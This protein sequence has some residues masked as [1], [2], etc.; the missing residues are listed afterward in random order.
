MDWNR[1]IERNS[2]VLKAI[3]AVLFA[4]LGLQG[5]AT[6]DRLPRPLHRA[7]LGILR[8][9]ESALRRLIVIAARGL[10]AKPDPARP[11]PQGLI[12]RSGGNRL[13]F[14]LFD[15]RKRFVLQRQGSGPLALPRIHIFGSDPRLAPLWSALATRP[16]P[17]PPPDDG[18]VNGR[19][20]SLRPAPL[21]FALDDLPRQA[22][23]PVHIA[24]EA[25]PS[26]GL[27]PNIGAQRRPRACANAT[28]SPL[29]RCNPTHREDISGA[30]IDRLAFASRGSALTLLA[31]RR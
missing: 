25:R 11:M 3:V 7:V 26:C 15:R 5:G 1:A 18:R 16:A 21:K 9:A 22:R 13:S 10:T 28:A 19:R 8:P 23:P 27:P 31:A 29:T 2:E 20:L 17:D 4:M 24:A 14:Q 30:A 6:V 12:I